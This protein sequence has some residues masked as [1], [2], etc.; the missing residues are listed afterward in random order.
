MPT[1]F[2]AVAGP[3]AYDT[4]LTFL[5]GP[6][7]D[8]AEYNEIIH[9][10]AQYS[11]QD[12]LGWL[13]LQHDSIDDFCRTISS[14]AS[15]RSFNDGSTWLIAHPSGVGNPHCRIPDSGFFGMPDSFNGSLIANPEFQDPASIDRQAYSF[16]LPLNGSATLLPQR[17]EA[18]GDDLN[19]FSEDTLGSRSSHHDQ[20]LHASDFFVTEGFGNMSPRSGH[21]GAA[22]ITG[23]P[24]SEYDDGEGS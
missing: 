5:D 23:P 2:A 9:T 20:A 17:P 21:Y 12:D 14:N 8:E 11:H 6:V 10:S 13:S 15:S 24:L 3:S 7:Y 1:G 16:A 19:L 4:S 22:G 18:N